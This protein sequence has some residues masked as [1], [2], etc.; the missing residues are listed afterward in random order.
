MLDI[1]AKY[2][3]DET[4]ENQ[5]SWVPVGGGAKILVA[6]ES[7][8]AFVEKLNEVH[9]RY[10]VALSVE[11]EESNKFGT[12]LLVDIMAETLLLGWE[13][14][15]FKGQEFPYSRENAK[16]LL[17]IKDFRK[18]VQDASRNL[19]NFRAKLEEAKTEEA[20]NA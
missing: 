20:G 13:G 17:A 12:K 14:V 1:F 10:K 3:T 7:S 8:P 5:G 19:D 4:L 16:T 2:A 15:A 6:R 18:V 9:E 11:G